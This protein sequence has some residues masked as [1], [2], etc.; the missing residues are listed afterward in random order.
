MKNLL[1]IITEEINA[2]V[3]RFE[4]WKLEFDNSSTSYEIRHDAYIEHIVILETLDSLMKKYV[5]L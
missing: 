3:A 2:E 1:S 5:V 4:K